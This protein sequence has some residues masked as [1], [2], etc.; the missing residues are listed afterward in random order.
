MSTAE[1]V[2]SRSW[3]F[4][5][6]VFASRLSSCMRKSRRRPA[7]L[8][9]IDHTA[10]FDDVAGET[11]ELLVHIQP[12]QQ[13]GQ[14]LLEAFLID[15]G[16][17]LG[18]P[19]IQPGAHARMDL[20]KSRTHVR[21]QDFQAAATLLEQF[22][23][24]L[25]LTG[26]R[27]NQVLDRASKHRMSRCQQLV[28]VIL[29]VTQNARPPQYVKDIHSVISGQGARY[30]THAGQQSFQGGGI[31]LEGGLG[32]LGTSEGNGAVHLAALQVTGEAL[33]QLAFRG[34]QLIRQTK[35]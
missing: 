10:D 31:D 14:L 35:A 26:A 27:R 4:E 25:A 9:A 17:E 22:A 6:K 29:L 5:D 8:V 15:V 2:V 33:P 28:G 12:L 18:E 11:I 30:V 32:P 1:R 13:H 21:D 20:G 3:D 24:P 23:Q 16:F 7:R 34:P 19:L